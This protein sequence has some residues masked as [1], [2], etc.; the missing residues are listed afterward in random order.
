M[1]TQHPTKRLASLNELSKAINNE[2]NAHNEW[3]NAHDTECAAIEKYISNKTLKNEDLWIEAISKRESLSITY[4][5]A[6]NLTLEALSKVS[7]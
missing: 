5:V 7:I 4:S 2:L 1:N 3:K 6:K